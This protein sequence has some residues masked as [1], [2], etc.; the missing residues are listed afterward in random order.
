ML[1]ITRIPF[2]PVA[3]L[4]S[5]L[6]AQTFCHINQLLTFLILLRYINRPVRQPCGQ[7]E[8]H[9]FHDIR[10]DVQEAFL[11][12]F[13]GDLG[14][15]G[16]S[17]Q[18]PGCH[19]AGLFS[20]LVIFQPFGGYAAN[21]YLFYFTAEYRNIFFIGSFQNNRQGTDYCVIGKIGNAVYFG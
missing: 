1:S 14:S 3:N 2:M 5:I 10:V 7:S 11:N 4:N 15:G 12:Y 13:V 6:L 20:Q 8:A 9:F 21:F 16:L 19:F 17:L 18:Y